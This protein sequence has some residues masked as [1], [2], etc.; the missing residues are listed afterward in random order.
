MWASNRKVYR[1][2][3]WANNGIRVRKCQTDLTSSF[4][5]NIWREIATS[6]VAID[7]KMSVGLWSRLLSQSTPPSSVEL[8]K[9]PPFD[10][11]TTTAA[12]LTQGMENWDENCPW[13]KQKKNSYYCSALYSDV[14][15]RWAV[16]F[17]S[18]K[19]A[20]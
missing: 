11:N 17:I 8:Y 18:V 7:E 6:L 4:A 9:S 20:Y 5:W 12:H 14:E 1:M 2:K 19:T 15:L 16:A 13:V 3:T 10:E